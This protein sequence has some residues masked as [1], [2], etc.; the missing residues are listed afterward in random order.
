MA[1]KKLVGESQSLLHSRLTT[2]WSGSLYLEKSIYIYIYYT[3]F[4]V[5][6]QRWMLV[7][8]LLILLITDFQTLKFLHFKLTVLLID[9]F[10]FKTF[11][12]AVLSVESVES[13]GSVESVINN[14]IRLR[15][16][17][18]TGWLGCSRVQVGPALSGRT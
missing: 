14:Y 10:K 11:I 18:K 15:E 1:D 17:T 5:V 2:G 8:T 4:I 3:I 7:T 13:V 6:I 9:I 16:N 12:T